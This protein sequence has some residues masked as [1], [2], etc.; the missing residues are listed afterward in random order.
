M[1]IYV[2]GTSLSETIV[3]CR[4]GNLQSVINDI[5][6]WCTEHDMIFNHSKCKELIISFAK[7]V[8][9]LRPL[10]FK[11]HCITQVPSAKVLG[12]YFSS[13]LTWNV[14]VEHIVCK[15][16]RDSSFSVYLNVVVLN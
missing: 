16:S 8:P 13:D 6:Q 14:H 5:D 4:Q 10:F 2:D 12:L 1:E 15:A 11:D 3:G 9:S 7:D